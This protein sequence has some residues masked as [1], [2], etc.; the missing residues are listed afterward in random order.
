MHSRV[1]EVW[2]GP[3]SQVGLVRST[4]SLVP[5][6]CALC[7]PLCRSWC[8]LALS[9]CTTPPR[10]LQPAAQRC[11][12]S[13]SIL[14]VGASCGHA[15]ARVHPD[16]EEH[17]QRLGRDPLAHGWSHGPYCWGS[18]HPLVLRVK[19]RTVLGFVAL[20][21]AASVGGRIPGG[22]CFDE[23]MPLA[24]SDRQGRS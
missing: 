16:R 15:V 20:A 19:Q 8:V 22:K 23:C 12:H 3:L 2:R 10:R 5:H 1:F 18:K 13:L 6:R 24:Y 4:C 7:S 21:S 11:A 17:T 14:F 9:I